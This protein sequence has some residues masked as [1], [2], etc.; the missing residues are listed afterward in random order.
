MINVAQPAQ[1]AM[2]K[3][4]NV[5]QQGGNADEFESRSGDVPKLGQSRR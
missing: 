3:W 2:V 5:K 1:S 4:Q